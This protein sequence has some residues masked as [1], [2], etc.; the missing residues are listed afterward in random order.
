MSELGN[1]RDTITC[2]R[3]F[4][5][6]ERFAV[7]FFLERAVERFVAQA[8]FV[9]LKRGDE[10]AVCGGAAGAAATMLTAAT[11]EAVSE[12]V[13]MLVSGATLAWPKPS[14][15]SDAA[16]AQSGGAWLRNVPLDII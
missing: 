9:R 10:G 4:G 11:I 14:T 15:G 12:I 6:F 8:R 1:V 2:R 7:V 3:I 16:R 13:R 5:V